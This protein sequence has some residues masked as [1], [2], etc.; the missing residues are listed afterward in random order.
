MAFL[1]FQVRSSA[2]C[3]HSISD[4]KRS[5]PKRYDYSPTTDSWVYSRDGRA[6]GDLLNDELTA[7]LGKEVS[8][9]MDH[10]S[11]KVEE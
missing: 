4:H 2:S 7:A 11:E 9:G 3:R 5:G 1:S 6:L 10:V 8:L